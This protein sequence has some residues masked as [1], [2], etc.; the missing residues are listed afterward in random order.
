VYGLFFEG[1]ENWG[2]GGMKF[3]GGELGVSPPLMEV[4]N[5]R[6]LLTNKQP[7]LCLNS[8]DQRKIFL[9]QEPRG[10]FPLVSLLQSEKINSD[11]FEQK[12]KTKNP[13]FTE[14]EQN[15]CL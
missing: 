3:R 10:V 5:T 7:I 15:T 4:D 12:I 11:G 9:L 2:F 6:K 13:K 1:F 8:Q 14:R